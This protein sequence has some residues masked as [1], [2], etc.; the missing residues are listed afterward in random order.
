MNYRASQA[1]R[2]L[3]VIPAPARLWRER[4]NPEENIHY[5]YGG[6]STGS[7]ATACRQAGPR[8]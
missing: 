1:T 2:Y 5:L 8:G 7:I 6:L 3:R 4:G